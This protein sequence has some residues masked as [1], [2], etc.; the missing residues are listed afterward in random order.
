MTIFPDHEGL[1]IASVLAVAAFLIHLAIDRITFVWYAA[2]FTP[3]FA[4]IAA[5]L[6]HWLWQRPGWGRPAAILFLAIV[7]AHA[8]VLYPV[9]TAQTMLEG[10]AEALFDGAIPWLKH[11]PAPGF[12]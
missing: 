6:F 12:V 9:A 10:Q 7:A 3:I 8:A 2:Q 5:G 11:L 4:V 1:C